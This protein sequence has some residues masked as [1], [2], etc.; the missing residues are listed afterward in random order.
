MG[1][2][3]CGYLHCFQY[4]VLMTSVESLVML[5]HTGIPHIWVYLEFP[6]WCWPQ[7]QRCEMGTKHRACSCSAHLACIE[8]CRIWR[9]SP[10]C[11]VF[12]TTIST[13]LWIIGMVVNCY[14]VHWYSLHSGNIVEPT[15]ALSGEAN[16]GIHTAHS[17]FQ[18]LASEYRH[19]KGKKNWIWQSFFGLF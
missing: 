9:E 18:A 15:P 12:T 2:L 19:E 13:W 6:Q 11:V 14:D 7:S 3:L 1:V 10:S 5:F 16:S 17:I 8:A 4:V